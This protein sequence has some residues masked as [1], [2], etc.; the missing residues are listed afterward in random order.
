[1]EL[2]LPRVLLAVLVGAA[3][4]IAGAVF[5]AL[6]RNPMADPYVLG[7]SAGAALGATLAFLF[8]LNYLPLRCGSGAFGC[9]CRGRSHGDFG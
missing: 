6:F 5:Q 4:A 8:P 3:L 7:V 9:L 1:M 2:R